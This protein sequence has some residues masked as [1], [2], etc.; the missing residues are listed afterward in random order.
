M[1][2]GLEQ[3]LKNEK[4]KRQQGKR[5]NLIGKEDAGAQFFGSQ[6]IQAARDYQ[7]IKEEEDVGMARW[8]AI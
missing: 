4:K 5:L 2:R 3:A 1:I 6:E 8:Q 7:A